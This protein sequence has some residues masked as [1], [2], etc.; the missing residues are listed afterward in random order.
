MKGGLRPMLKLPY[1]YAV[2]KEQDI[3]LIIQGIFE[4]PQS[5]YY[6]KFINIGGTT[7][8]EKIN[9]YLNERRCLNQFCVTCSPPMKWFSSTVRGLQIP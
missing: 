6:F 3:G 4:C 2:S 7:L 9:K 1:S 8:H 5:L